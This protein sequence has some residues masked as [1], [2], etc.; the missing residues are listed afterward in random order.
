VLAKKVTDFLDTPEH[1]DSE[2]PNFLMAFILVK[3]VSDFGFEGSILVPF[4][5]G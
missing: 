1:V 5:G 3:R 2:K 4:R